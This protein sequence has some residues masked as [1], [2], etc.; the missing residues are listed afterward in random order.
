MNVFY[1]ALG[2]G[3]SIA[4][5]VLLISFVCFYLTF[6]TSRRKEKKAP[7]FDIPPGKIYEPF[8]EQ[9]IAWQKEARNIPCID[10]EITSFDGLKL[11]GKFYEYKKG[12]PIELMMHGYRGT[13]ERDL[14]GGIQRCFSLGRSCLIIDQ[15]ACGRSEGH[16]ITFGVKEHRDCLDWI[17]YIISNIDKDAKIILCG[18]SMGAS[19]VLMASGKKLPDNVV[20][21]LAD[22][23]YTSADAI[24]KKVIKQMKLPASLL[25]PFV[26]LGARIYGGFN[27]EESPAIENVKVSKL[28]T[29]F[30]HGQADDFVPYEMSVENFNACSAEKQLVSMPKAGHGLCFVIEP[31]KYLETLAKFTIEHYR[32]DCELNCKRGNSV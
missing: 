20:G 6:F 5:L 12:A 22:C 14:C 31:E 7:E 23:G 10:A 13:S 16:V 25:Y 2:I 19:T 17:D 3:G 28:P 8:R 32:V 18:I 24:I 4:V 26:K 21:V 15:R 9:M 1:W 27:L 29:I 11:K 30:Y